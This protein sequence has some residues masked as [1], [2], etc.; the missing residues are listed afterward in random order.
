MTDEQERRLCALEELLNVLAARL[1][2][3]EVL[4]RS[5]ELWQEAERS[6]K[7][8]EQSRQPGD[9]RPSWVLRVDAL[10]Q[11]IGTPWAKPK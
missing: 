9:T 3:V 8:L 5:E 11:R 1:S 4:V 6:A 7:Q 2:E 10:M